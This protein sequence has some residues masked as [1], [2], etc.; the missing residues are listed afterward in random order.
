[1]KIMGYMLTYNR[2]IGL[3]LVAI[4]IMLLILFL[5]RKKAKS[6]LREICKGLIISCGTFLL[7]GMFT[8]LI[9]YENNKD[10]LELT[11][12][13]ND[14]QLKLSSQNEPL[15]LDG[16]PKI[17]QNNSSMT[18]TFNKKQGTVLKA[19]GVLFSGK[20]GNAGNGISYIPAELSEKGKKIK[21][22]VPIGSLKFDDQIIRSSILNK[23]GSTSKV[24][25]DELE[26]GLTVLRLG[27]II[28]DSKNNI[29]SYYYIIRPKAVA[30]FNYELKISV[31]NVN[32]KYDQPC[33]KVLPP[34]VIA[35]QILGTDSEGEDVSN[36]ENNLA[37]NSDGL[38]NYAF[39]VAKKKDR[40]IKANQFKEE[41]G[42]GT[43]A[44]I[45]S[46]ATVTSDP[47]FILNYS[48][49]N[50]QLVNQDVGE[51][52]EIIKDY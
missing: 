33:N 34:L 1:M 38:D 51:L 11:K 20:D 8:S 37:K 50:R 36:I 52:D 49:P 46:N 39:H 2:L 43:M 21:L 31:N 16:N 29:T 4:G 47:T 9:Q 44:D 41:G 28:K 12:K 25:Y 13:D 18:I 30:G 6:V 27:I 15:I 45:D 40:T 17:S 22:T 19:M 26:Q 7:V 32:Y 48:V 3:D 10:N 23:N 24:D 14:S 42:S 35:N 5:V